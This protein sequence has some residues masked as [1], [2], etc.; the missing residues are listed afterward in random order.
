MA[1]IRLEWKEVLDS[2]YSMP[3]VLSPVEERRLHMMKLLLRMPADGVA[4]TWPTEAAC[5]GRLIAVRW[6]GGV[7]CPKCD[8]AQVGFLQQRQAYYCKAC[9]LQFTA[10]SHSIFHR[11][12][13][14]L[15]KWFR[16]TEL[17]IRY[18]AHDPDLNYPTGHGLKDELE[19]SYAAAHA[20]KKK[21]LS[22]LFQ[23]DGG[24]LGR[25][26]AVGPP[27]SAPAG[28]SVGGLEEFRWFHSLV[29]A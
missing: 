8:S 29:I 21:S 12:H 16:A 20:I 13:V 3:S 26:V 27:V 22:D 15:Q 5:R 10:Q 6:P 14:K 9:H 1:I 18:N 4:K 24:L 7:R 19:I 25:C 17:L 23:T 2:R 11:S 28:I